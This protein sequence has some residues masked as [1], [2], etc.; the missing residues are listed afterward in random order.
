MSL[1]TLNFSCENVKYPARK[2]FAKT[3]INTVQKQGQWLCFGCVRRITLN[4]TCSNVTCYVLCSRKVSTLW[5]RQLFCFSPKCGSQVLLQR[6][7]A[8][9]RAYLFTRVINFQ[10]VLT[11]TK[12]LIDDSNVC[13]KIIFIVHPYVVKMIICFGRKFHEILLNTVYLRKLCDVDAVD[14]RVLHNVSYC[15]AQTSF[16][17]SYVSAFLMRVQSCGVSR[18]QRCVQ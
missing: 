1:L 2:H 5:T 12:A 16:R 13:V 11:S 6:T 17:M 10:H 3:N 4:V 8:G 7:I 9:H 15:G 14:V 18:N